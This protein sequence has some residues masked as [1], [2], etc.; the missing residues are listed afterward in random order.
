M[1]ENLDIFYGIEGPTVRQE[2]F[3]DA[4]ERLKLYGGA[5]GGGKSW[6]ICAE[7]I[8]LSMMFQGNRGFM[9]RQESKSFKE[10]TLITMM[11]LI[12]EIETFT[13][14]KILAKHNKADCLLTFASGSTIVYGGLGGRENTDRVKSME[15]G[16]FCVDEASECVDEDINMLESRLRWKLPNGK[17]PRFVGMF[18]S[19]PEPCYLKD[20]FVNPQQQGEKHKNRIFVQALPRDN[21]WLPPDYVEH[22]S[23]GKP[24][25][26]IQRY[27]DG[28]WDAA[29]GQIWPQFDFNI[30]VYPNQN[31]NFIIPV[32]TE[33]HQHPCIFAGYDHGQTNAAC[34][35]AA[36]TDNDG[37][38]FIYDEYYSPGLVS[39]HSENIKEIFDLDIMH[40]TVADPSIWNVTGERDGKEWSLHDE[41]ID[42]DIYF[43]KASNAVE[44]G[45][46][47]VGEYLFLDETHIHPITGKSGSPR[48]FIAAKCRNLIRELPEYIWQTSKRLL[49]DNPE[50]P[51]KRKD[52]ACDAMRYLIMSRPGV[53]FAVS[54]EVP[55]GS[56]KYYKNQVA[57]KRSHSAI[58]RRVA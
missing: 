9:C 56:F 17:Y 7:A 58:R 27:I 57:N 45:I 5:L 18:A 31:S 12:Y 13:K 32:P 4:G 49:V 28:S 11:S 53:D 48:L 47:R 39:Y 37:N 41:Y 22:I 25:Y 35:L 8:R 44:A 23:A 40:Y 30:H 15:I 51:V 16:F 24:D 19:N 20:K 10:T 2:Q 46:N 26:W 6:A 14:Q 38:V 21:N 55:H 1:S 54:D 29:E 36:Y 52:H 33:A 43:Q 50:R 3:R 42:N 34:Y